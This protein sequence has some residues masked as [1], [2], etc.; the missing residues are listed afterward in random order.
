MNTIRISVFACA[1]AAALQ[2]SAATLFSGGTTDWKIAYEACEKNTPVEYGA[3]E[4][5]AALKT[6]SGAEFAA[7]EG[8][9]GAKTLYIG[10]DRTLP[11]PGDEVVVIRLKG[12]SVELVGNEPRAA[13]HAVYAFLQRELGVRW[14]WPGKD[15]EFIPKRE[16]WE[17]PTKGEWRHTP[18]IKYRGF[19]CC[20]D[21]YKR[22]QFLDWAARNFVTT[23]RHGF[24]RDAERRHGFYNF[25]SSHNAS[26][27]RRKDLFA[28]HPEYFC[29]IG[30][31]RVKV[32]LC[33]SSEGAVDEVVKQLA[34]DIRG[35]KI[36]LDVLS[37][38]PADNQDYCKCAE[39]KKMSV[40]DGWFGFYN[41]VVT[42]LRKDF[43]DVK[44]ATL[45]YQGYRAA[46]SFPVVETE[47]VEYASHGRC[48]RH[49]WNDPD[50]PPNARDLKLMDTWENRE[51][52]VGEYG[53]E[54]DMFIKNNIWTP[55]FS[56]VSDEIDNAARKK[57]IC[58]ITEI[59]MSPRNGPDTAVDY[60]I[61]RLTTLL[62]AQK[63]W[64]ASLTVEAFF[65]DLTKTAF[66]PAAAPMKRYLETMDRAWGR[67]HKMHNEILGSGLWVCK[68]VL[69]EPTKA[70]CDAAF[71]EA[72]KAIAGAT[73]Q[74]KLAFV[75]EK[76]LYRQ[77]CDL[78]DAANGNSK[79]L[80]LPKLAKAGTIPSDA[81]AAQPLV[82]RDGKPT[83]TTVRTAW[84]GSAKKKVGTTM[85]EVRVQFEGV[86]SDAAATVRFFAST[87]IRYAF[88]VAADG[89]T[90]AE[91]I[92]EV[93]IR[94]SSYAP[95]WKGARRDGA[96]RLAIPAAAFKAPV[97]QDERL[98]MHFSVDGKAPAGLPEKDNIDI[99]AAFT[100]IR[101][102]DVPAFSCQRVLNHRRISKPAEKA[103]FQDA[104]FDAAVTETAAEAE[105]AVDPKQRVFLFQAVGLK[106]MSEKVRET[107]RKAVADGGIVMFYY[108]SNE[109]IAGFMGDKAFATKLRNPSGGTLAERRAVYCKPGDWL[110]R[111]FTKVGSRMRGG[112]MPA[113]GHTPVNPEGWVDYVRGKGGENGVPV[114]T[115][116][117]YGKGMV[118][119]AGTYFAVSAQQILAN[120]W[121]E[122]CDQAK[123][124]AK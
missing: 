12:D 80:R 117:P 90:R 92:S 33:F 67:D 94:E 3:R 24:R 61:N 64:D 6:M 124:G 104:G 57:H 11:K 119:V 53:Y 34:G 82:G 37:I 19:H 122:Y 29:E 88:T 39:C 98:S 103:A 43:P 59:G 20:G 44:F 118:F 51:V 30:G 31:R 83:A 99:T 74:Q 97:L 36:P 8:A 85:D 111:P 54:Y 16:S 110:E 49:C 70:A 95:D 73:D 76:A 71:A 123:E 86:P 1:A 81:C 18:S 17:V 35:R 23:H 65:D 84:V 22:D 42:K 32:N 69:D 5:Q 121:E 68:S 112:I 78:L 9:A 102:V 38:F 93:G 77:W 66:G 87:G 58:L 106:P 75:R 10:V 50:C 115:A 28:E 52:R 91:C 13:L 62:Y 2:A 63:M 72:E 109:D 4:L 55:F 107:V 48:N 105:A 41:K 26:L 56:F 40:S 7:G 100:S 108:Y 120:L 21:W 27:N 113:Y 89:T 116:H 47:F 45:A 14:L 25:V 15:G 101:H 60:I 96:V 46:P 114:L 79:V